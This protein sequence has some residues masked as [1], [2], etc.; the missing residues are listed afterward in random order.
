[1]SDSSTW[2]HTIDFTS[3]THGW[4]II[5]YSGEPANFF[6]TYQ[7]GVGFINSPLWGCGDGYCSYLRIKYDFGVT[8]SNLTALTV[9]AQQS[10][11]G[12]I[13]YG[14]FD[15][16]TNRSYWTVSA[17]QESGSTT[18]SGSGSSID[19]IS[20]EINTP[21]TIILSKLIFTGVGQNPFFK[22]QG[23]VDCPFCYA[24]IG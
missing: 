21:V 1:M 15:L 20:G 16:D 6:G 13:S 10:D 17:G 9:F 3:E 11:G 24:A 2:S 18:I 23:P 8:V 12:S 22:N 14:I 5:P 19:V 4:S 7:A